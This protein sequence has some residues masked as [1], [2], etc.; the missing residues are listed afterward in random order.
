[1]ASEVVLVRHGATE[2]SENGRHTSHTDLPLTEQG[3]AQAKT[4]PGRLAAWDFALVLTSPMQRARE[5]ARLAGFGDRAVVDDDLC[6]LDYGADEGRTTAEIREQ[7]PGWTVWEG[8]ASGESL[9]HAGERADRV[10]AGAGAVEGAVLVF[11]H[12][13]ALRILI[14]R[15]LGLPA[16]RGRLFALAT[17][18]VSVLGYEREQRVLERFN[19]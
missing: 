3:I 6:E 11:G 16:D 5:T 17:A 9:H 14:A 19:A 12:G 1:V 8:S 13:H 10:I 15:W 4:L 18:T 7:Q 2:W